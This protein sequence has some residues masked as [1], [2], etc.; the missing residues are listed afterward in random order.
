[1]NLSDKGNSHMLM[2]DRNSDAMVD[3]VMEW[4]DRHVESARVA[5]TR[6]GP[7]KDAE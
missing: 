4:I 1:M 6:G 2:Q 3:R 5:R 7:T